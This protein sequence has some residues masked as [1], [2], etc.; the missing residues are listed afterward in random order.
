MILICI[1]TIIIDCNAACCSSTCKAGSKT[2]H[3]CDNAC[4]CRSVSQ[5]FRPC[6]WNDFRTEKSFMEDQRR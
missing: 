3:S 2:C 6:F 5:S 1:F 4:A